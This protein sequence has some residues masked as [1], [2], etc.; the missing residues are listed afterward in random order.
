MLTESHVDRC[1][2]DFYAGLPYKST[3]EIENAHHCKSENTGMQL[4][5]RLRRSTSRNKGSKVEALERPFAQETQS[6]VF[7]SRLPPDLPLQWNAKLQ[8]QLVAT[9]VY[10]A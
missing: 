9:A 8:P 3:R 2:L 7:E 4:A 10:P 1:A 5:G 6:A